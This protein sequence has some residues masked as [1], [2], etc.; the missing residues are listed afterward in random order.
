MT[1][2]RLRREFSAHRRLIPEKGDLDDFIANVGS[3]RS[4]N[5]T[6]LPSP[7][8]GDD[9]SGLWI[10]TSKRDYVAYPA[11]A[12]VTRRAAIIC[13]ELA[14]MLL[15]HDPQPDEAG[16]EGLASSF[17]THINPSVAARVLH[18]KHYAHD[19][20][21]EA[22]G[23]GTLFTLELSKRENMNHSR[24]DRVYDRLR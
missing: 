14:H 21:V 17:V 23:L 19:L 18:R 9:P 16:L 3:S 10:A 15:G 8:S 12:T 5:I 22:E 11:A 7:L 2:S 24:Q 4:R 13:H 20:E 1:R 6:L